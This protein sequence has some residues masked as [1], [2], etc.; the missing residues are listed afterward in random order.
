MKL[1]S[2]DKKELLIY[3]LIQ[4]HYERGNQRK[5]IKNIWRIY[6]YPMYGI[7]YRSVMRYMSEN[8]KRGKTI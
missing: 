7:S 6:I 5:M 2:T 1:K 8:R 3:N 4:E